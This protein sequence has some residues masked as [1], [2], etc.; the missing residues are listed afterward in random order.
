MSFHATSS[1]NVPVPALAEHR[2][3]VAGSIV[4]V[5]NEQAAECRLGLLL[6]VLLMLL[7]G[8]KL[9]LRPRLFVSYVVKAYFK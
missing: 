1:I 4:A 6:L 8:L 9:L 2:Q 3:L 7:L 5:R